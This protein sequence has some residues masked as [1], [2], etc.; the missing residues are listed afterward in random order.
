MLDL[1]RAILSDLLRVSLFMMAD[2][3]PVRVQGGACIAA[4]ERES[5]RGVCFA[6]GMQQNGVFDCAVS[7][8][9][10]SRDLQDGDTPYLLD[11]RLMV[12]VRLEQGV[13]MADLEAAEQ[14]IGPDGLST[15]E[16][17]TMLRLLAVASVDGCGV[18]PGERSSGPT[19]LSEA[20]ERLG[21]PISE[22]MVRKLLRQASSQFPPQP[23]AC[24]GA[25]ARSQPLRLTTS[26]MNAK[27][28]RTIESDLVIG[29][30]SKLNTAVSSL[31][32]VLSTSART[33]A[34]A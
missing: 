28:I 34:Q 27:P 24:G 12:A 3:V 11:E 19:Q 17:H 1:H 2:L 15:K 8:V 7:M 13:V 30:L 18:I 10:R 22:N 14:H 29:P 9:S 20:V 5:L 33:A 16:Q 23:Q 4:G 26:A 21:I 32:V 31:A 6:H 25:A